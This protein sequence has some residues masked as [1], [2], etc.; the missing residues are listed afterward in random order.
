MMSQPLPRITDARAMTGYRLWI[1][2]SDGAEGMVD[3]SDLV[4]RGVFA[5]WRDPTVWNAVRIDPHS[6]TVSW[7]GDLD[8]D[9][10][11][12]YTDITGKALPGAEAAA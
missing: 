9:P 1:R 4:G 7:P 3:L 2:F 6:R 11:L 5:A 8:L 12:L 10:D